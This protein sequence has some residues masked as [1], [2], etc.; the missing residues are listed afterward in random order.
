MENIFIDTSIF[1]KENFFEGKRLECA[2][3]VKKHNVKTKK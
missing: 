3:C 1:V 2:I